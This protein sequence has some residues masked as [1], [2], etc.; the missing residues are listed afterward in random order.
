MNTKLIGIRDFRQ[1]ISEYAKKAQKNKSRYIITSHNIPLFEIVPF[2]N[3]NALEVY[4]E[5]LEGLEDV[6]NN[7]TIPQKDVVKK[8]SLNEA[9]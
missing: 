9:K 3:A 7:R 5:V 6:K 4:K 8:Y 1:N 2:N